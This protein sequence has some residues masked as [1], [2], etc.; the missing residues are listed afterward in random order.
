MKAIIID[1]EER[2]RVS[3]RLLIQEFC[4][5]LVI[6]DEC[7]N[8]PEAVKSIHKNQPEIIFLDIE[9][10]GHSGLELLEFFNEKDVHFSIV[11]T[12]AYNNYALK[13]FKLSAVDYLLKPI[14]PLELK[15][16]VEL[17][18][19]KKNQ[20]E[21]LIALKRNLEQQDATLGIPVSGK[22]LF[23]NSN[24]ILYLKAEG[25]YTQIIKTD[26]SSLLVS[27]NLKSFEDNLEFDS[28]FMRI[29]KSYIVNTNYINA[30]IKS[31]GGSV[32]L[33]NNEEIPASQEKIVELLEIIKLL[34]R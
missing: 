26:N 29:H 12:T 33:I 19:K 6:M 7:K 10:P 9:M 17:V 5:E 30:V 31:N 24:D 2:A 16:A 25:A 8:I 11:F 32:E 15:N 3:L 28:K 23:V 20:I 18:K 27:R 14:N 22:I 13:A 21:N 34:K 1:D 4:P